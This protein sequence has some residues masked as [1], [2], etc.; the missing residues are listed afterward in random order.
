MTGQSLFVGGI[1]WMVFT[2]THRVIAKTHQVTL[3]IGWV[4][5][6]GVKEPTQDTDLHCLWSHYIPLIPNDFESVLTGAT[7]GVCIPA[8]PYVFPGTW[9]VCSK[10]SQHALINKPKTGQGLRR[11]GKWGKAAGDDHTHI[12]ILV[13]LTHTYPAGS[14]LLWMHQ[15]KNTNCEKSIWKGAG[16]PWSV[17]TSLKDGLGHRWLNRSLRWQGGTEI[18]RKQGD[19]W[20]VVW[21]SNRLLWGARSCWPGWERAQRSVVGAYSH[22]TWRW[23]QQVTHGDWASRTSDVQPTDVG[24]FWKNLRQDTIL[25]SFSDWNVEYRLFHVRVS[26]ETIF[27]LSIWSVFIVSEMRQ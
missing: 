15:V 3:Q 27:N 25:L 10:L 16:G 8:V 6:K 23:A 20:R 19:W 14:V 17:R 5:D 18:E 22:E 9:L 13:H 7:A 11:E 2:L 24:Y 4:P 12:C 26:S 21:C 1:W